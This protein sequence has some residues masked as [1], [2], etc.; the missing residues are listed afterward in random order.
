MPAGRLIKVKSKPTAKAVANKALREVR[1]LKAGEELKYSETVDSTVSTASWA[2]V[3]NDFLTI[4]QG[5]S[6]ITRDGEKMTLQSVHIKGIVEPDGD[7]DE[8]SLVRVVAYWQ[9]DLSTFSLP[10][11]METNSVISFYNANYKGKIRVLMDKTINVGP[12]TTVASTGVAL[13]SYRYATFEKRLKLRKMIRYDTGSST[14]TNGRI[15]ILVIGRNPLGANYPIV[16][17]NVRCYYTDN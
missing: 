15:T 11:P 4:A 16:D 14:P 1:K 10:L 12:A 3:G 2:V 8:G 9:S 5:D 17:T 6:A 7:C 13:S